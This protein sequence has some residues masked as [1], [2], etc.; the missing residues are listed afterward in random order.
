MRKITQYWVPAFVMMALLGLTACEWELSGAK[1]EAVLAFSETRVDNLMAGWTAG[2]YTAFS[3]DFDTDM[4]D[5]IPAT[6]FTN[7]KQDFDGQLGTY[8]SRQV[9]RVTRADEFYVVTYQARFE[10]EDLVEITVA[11]HA[12]DRSIAFLAFDSERTSWSTF[13]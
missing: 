1:K 2:D 7:L 4:L 5:E 12:S 11:F 9:D 3:R 8:I 13:Q 10:E 6:T